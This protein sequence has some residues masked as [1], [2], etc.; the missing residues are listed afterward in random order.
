M[1]YKGTLLRGQ[2]VSYRPNRYRRR[3]SR[4]VAFLQGLAC[5]L[6][7]AWLLVAVAR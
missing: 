1:T 7:L 6:G 3:A 4:A 2:S 5:G